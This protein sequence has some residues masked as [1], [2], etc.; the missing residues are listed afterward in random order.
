MKVAFVETE[1]VRRLGR[2]VS[3]LLEAY[4]GMP[5]LGVV[6]GE[7][8]LGKSWAVDDLYVNRGV[9]YVRATR[10]WTPNGMLRTILNRLGERPAWCTTDNL[11]R[12]SEVLKARAIEDPAKGL[13]VIDESNYLLQKT[14]AALPP[15]ILD[16]V[17]DLA[18]M[19]QTP[20]LLVGEPEFASVLKGQALTS[21][22]YQ[23]FWERVLLAEEFKA[24]K[25]AEIS[26]F[27]RELCELD[28]TADAADAAQAATQGNL[29]RLV[30]F[31]VRL[32]R[33]CKAS[34]QKTVTPEMVDTVKGWAQKRKRTP[35]AETG[36]RKRRA[37]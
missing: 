22:G 9:A 12:A 30:L 18:D 13:L 1:N 16:T 32:E 6:T 7:V 24:L 17:R 33:I 28:I 19:A 26:A 2:V 23:R 3:A 11:D 4:E 37:A 29:R 25:S 14:S 36:S 21:R 27:C 34:K 20:V 8:G 35:A 31:L 15:A 10:T 5:R